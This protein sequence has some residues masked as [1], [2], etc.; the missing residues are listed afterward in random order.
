MLSGSPPEYNTVVDLALGKAMVA[1]AGFSSW[2]Y[3][4]GFDVSIP[5]YSPLVDNLDNEPVKK[6]VAFF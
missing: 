4:T 1:G 3:R 5:M 6:F 2:T